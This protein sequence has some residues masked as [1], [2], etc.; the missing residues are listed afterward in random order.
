MITMQ[1]IADKA[2]VSR[3][4]VSYVLNAKYKKAKISKATNDKILAVAEKLGYRR[5]ALAQSMKTGKTNIIGV[6]GGLYG[7]YAMDII[8]GIA[9]V[10]TQNGYLLK[11]LPD[12]QNADIND[13]ARICIEQRIDGVICRIGAVKDVELLHKEL[14][15]HSIPLVVV[16]NSL[17][18]DSFSQV[19]S[20]N[21]SGAQKATKY[22]WDAGHRN[23]VNVITT[24][25]PIARTLGYNDMMRE[26]GGEAQ[27]VKVLNC[28]EVSDD[29]QKIIKQ[30]LVKI[31][32]SAFFC[33]SDPVA[34]QILSVALSLGIK[35]PQEL[36][37]IGFAGLSYT[38]FSAPT[39][40]T[41]RQPFREMGSE[42]MQILLSE[43]NYKTEIKKIKLP[44]ELIIRNSVQ[45][46]K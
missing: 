33:T 15:V 29:F 38:A 7:S 37:V 13:V 36:S 8:N 31:K 5:N 32:P 14:Q 12:E 3:G 44:V 4:T 16:D 45:A 22:L 35:V 2:K 34:M 18:F 27:H 23:I 26:L 10:A 6:V 17:P 25:D 11:I 19:Y 21:Y 46:I 42:A 39:L 28:S 20:D 43:I 24:T 30:T 9:D 40:T 41:V 1:D